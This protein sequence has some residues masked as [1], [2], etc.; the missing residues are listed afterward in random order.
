[1]ISFSKPAEDFRR[2]RNQAALQEIAARLTGRS[3]ELLSFEEIRDKFHLSA[4]SDRGRQEIPVDAIVGSVGRYSDF[5]RSFLPRR[6]SDKDRWARVQEGMLDMASLPPIE[7]YKIDQVYFVLDGNHRVSVARQ[8][9]ITHLEALV[10]EYKSDVPLGP[11]DKPDDLIIKA[12]YA[13]FLK[14]T[15]MKEVRPE[16]DLQVTAP[17]Q[18][19]QIQTYIEAQRYLL[20]QETERDISVEE[21]TGHWYDQVYLPLVELIREQGLLRDFPDRTETDLFLWI[22]SHQASLEKALGWRIEPEAA[23]ADLAAGHSPRPEGMIARV[24]EKLLGAIKP[25]QLEAGPAPGQWRQQRLAGRAEERLFAD[26]LTPITGDAGGWQALDMA[27]TVAQWEGGRILGLH[28]IASDDQKE[29]QA[30]QSIKAEFQQRCQA[31]GVPGNLLV[32]SG[33]VIRQIC[34]RARWTDLIV[35]YPANPPGSKL[36][37]RLSSGSRTV[38][39]RSSR[40]VLTVP[41]AASAP[42]RLLLAYDGSPKAQEALFVAAYLVSRWPVSLVVLSVLEIEKQEDRLEEAKHYLEDR[43]IEASFI[44]VWGNVV[45]AILTVA[46]DEGCNLI[47]MGGYSARPVREVVLGS[48]VDQ[49]LRESRLPILV[50]R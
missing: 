20:G 37:S 44:S 7:V 8:L 35:M 21:A 23:V 30:V 24:E 13:G 38:I 5:T 48:T 12:E 41:G 14:S 1:M 50:C 49:I 11:D 40:P 46:A 33:P 22:L 15:R 27:L 2:A 28:I 26:I 29:S 16:A 36:L 43:N 32:E 34:E 10:T 3:V 4:R 6:D 39:Y 17:G 9:G 47:L 31:A 18:Y 42:K 19:W 25:D 45:T